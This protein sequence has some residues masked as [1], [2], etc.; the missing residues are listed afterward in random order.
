MITRIEKKG[1][2]LIE[3]LV[4]IA[5]IAL[6]LSILMPSLSKA[7]KLCQRVICASNERQQFLAFSLYRA[8]YNSY[9]PPIRYLDPYNTAEKGTSAWG[10]LLRRYLDD[11]TELG[12]RVGQVDIVMYC[13]SIPEG[14][15]FGSHSYVSYGYN[16]FGVGGNQPYADDGKHMIRSLLS[17]THDTLLLVD[18]E[19]TYQVHIGWYEAYP[20]PTG[21]FVY[22]RHDDK[23]NVLFCDGH[24]EAKDRTYLIS[25]KVLSA[26]N[27]PIANVSP[28]YG[29]NCK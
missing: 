5:I 19:S 10:V 26:P 29:G 6:L 23:A 24:V 7:K 17:P 25:Q 3:L 12:K 22:T 27:P 15:R 13:P 4:V 20:D 9:Y 11:A 18:C 8:D 2:T 16:R 21:T 14:D 1:F 28:W